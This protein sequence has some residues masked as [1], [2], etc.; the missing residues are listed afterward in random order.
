MYCSDCIYLK[1]LNLSKN[2]NLF[3]IDCSGCT[4]LTSITTYAYDGLGFINCKKLKTINL[5]TTKIMTS[6]APNFTNCKS[7]KKII[8]NKKC[9][10]K[11]Y[12]A[13]KKII[14]SSLK[15]AHL[16]KVKIVKG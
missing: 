8:L 1:S 10:K 5:K 16:N 2:T 14:K 11:T 4:K 9:D 15:Q 7:L 3:R 6:D 13:N 12:A